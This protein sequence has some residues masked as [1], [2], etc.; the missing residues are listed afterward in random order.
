MKQNIAH[1]CQPS[2]VN[3]GIFFAPLMF[4]R[5]NNLP[6]PLTMIWVEI[7]TPPM[8]TFLFDTL[9]PYPIPLAIPVLVVFTA[10]LEI[11]GIL[12]VL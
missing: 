12:L 11:A 4:D 1:G 7:Y 6:P 8:E 10:S 2:T 9:L 5:L 3:C